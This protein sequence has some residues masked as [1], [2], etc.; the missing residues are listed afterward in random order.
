MKP[1]YRPTRTEDLNY[2]QRDITD[3]A[4]QMGR[5]A[6]SKSL[7]RWEIGVTETAIPHGAIIGAPAYLV[8]AI[9]A[10]NGLACYVSETRPADTKYLYLI[11]SAPCSAEI[12]VL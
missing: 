4:N 6:G 5:L 10:T 12:E 8:L 1:G 11:A 3:F 9:R 7:G 2:I